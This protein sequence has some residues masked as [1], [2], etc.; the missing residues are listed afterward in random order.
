MVLISLLTS[1]LD[2]I[3]VGNLILS[4]CTVI[5]EVKLVNGELKM[6]MVHEAYINV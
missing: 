3:C 4:L 2:T 6:C 1:I 5:F